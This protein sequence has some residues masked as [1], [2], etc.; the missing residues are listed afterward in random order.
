GVDTEATDQGVVADPARERVIQRVADQRVGP[1]AAG[2]VPNAGDGGEARG[3]AARQVDG[4]GRGGR[5][6]TQRIAAAQEVGSD[7][8]DAGER[9]TGDACQRCAVEDDGQGVGRRRPSDAQGVDAEITD[10]RVGPIAD[11]IENEIVA[12]AG[13]DDV[14][15]CATGDGVI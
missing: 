9:A 1:R 13:I 15:A 7:N 11:G 8:L 14:I 3:A 2:D 4:H 5:A 10:D 12:G 6:I